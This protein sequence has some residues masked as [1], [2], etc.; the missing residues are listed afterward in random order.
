MVSELSYTELETC[1]RK[2][3]MRGGY[4]GRGRGHGRGNRGDMGPQLP[5]SLIN[6]LGGG[7]DDG[8]YSGGL[9]RG[10]GGLSRKQKR[11]EERDQ[12][13]KSNV[14]YFRQRHA[15]KQQQQIKAAKEQRLQHQEDAKRKLSGVGGKA[16]VGC[17]VELP[18]L[19]LRIFL[20]ALCPSP[21]CS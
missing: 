19:Q 2:S 16:P 15:A 18:M 10:K 17:I 7:D 1:E 3:A 9:R 20:L 12:K 8:H 11:K 13:K 4:R 21:Q 5:S 14:D 6:Q